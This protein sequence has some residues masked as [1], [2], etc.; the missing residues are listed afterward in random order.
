MNKEFVTKMVKAKQL[1][2]EAL[3]EILPAHVV[4]R[5]E[6]AEGELLQIAKEC[7]MNAGEKQD[8]AGKSSSRDKNKAR[9]VTIE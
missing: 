8:T 9:K 6:Q 5:M 1:E 3:K 2:L 4:K 7:F